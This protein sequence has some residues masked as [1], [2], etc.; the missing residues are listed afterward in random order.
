M[1]GIN[2]NWVD[3][4]VVEAIVGARVMRDAYPESSPVLSMLCLELRE[5]IKVL[6]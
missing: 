1:L 6:A 5:A 4:Y 3:V 2:G